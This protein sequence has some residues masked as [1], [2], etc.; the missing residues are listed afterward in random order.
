MTELLNAQVL[1]LLTLNIG[2]PSPERAER[3][4]DWFEGRPED[5]FVLT[6]T[7]ASRG[8]E[9]MAQRF[10]AAG[11]SVTFQKPDPGECGV[12]IVARMAT[13]SG[14][15][16][17]GLDYLAA[18]AASVRLEG[19]GGIEVIGFYV[20]SRDASIEKTQRKQK[21]I[22]SCL[23]TFKAQD[24]RSDQ[25]IVLG[26][27]NI[28]EPNHKPRYSFFLPWEY[29][30]YTQLSRFRLEDAFRH[31]H[32]EVNEYSWVG[33]TGD[34]YRYDHAF[35]SISLLN[36][37]VE[38][39]Y[40]HDTRDAGLSDHSGLAVSLRVAS[41]TLKPVSKLKPEIPTLFGF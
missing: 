20:P 9:L 22:E 41:K 7:R 17:G 15:W 29:D 6:E 10:A 31:L 38:C 30:F 13:H 16:T 40:V 39:S 19:A 24:G 37:I 36:R 3:Q 5:V 12:M 14:A 4:M 11:Y 25:L 18:R 32:R 26:D 8:C 28:L 34:G 33:R 21:F 1:H 27:L 35:V 2:N 23:A